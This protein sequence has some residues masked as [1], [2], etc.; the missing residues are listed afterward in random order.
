MSQI[1]DIIQALLNLRS[2]CEGYDDSYDIQI[3]KDYIKDRERRIGFMQN[4]F[5]RETYA[6][7]ISHEPYFRNAEIVQMVK[8]DRMEN[9]KKLY[10]LDKDIVLSIF[11]TSFQFSAINDREEIKR[12]LE[13]V[14]RIKHFHF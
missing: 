1:N 5:M 8:Q 6:K 9:L 10:C 7:F 11:T 2:H 12:Y 13:A 3:I 14:E 4:D